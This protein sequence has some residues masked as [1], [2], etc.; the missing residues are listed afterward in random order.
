MSKREVK[1]AK[2]IAGC[3]IL[4]ALGVVIMLLGAVIGIGTYLAPLIAGGSLLLVRRTYGVKYQVIAWL[5]VGILSLMLVP[6]L[7]QNLMFLCLFGCYPIFWPYLQRL[8]RVLRLGIKLVYFN[9][10]FI[11]IELLLMLLIVPEAIDS[12]LFVL[13]VLLGNVVFLAYDAVLPKL[14][15]LMTHLLGKF[16]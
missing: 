3:G 5:A 2:I 7:E 8:N 15:R 14:E 12:L 11:S 10:V 6:A 4:T 13:L 16:L 1:P 9:A